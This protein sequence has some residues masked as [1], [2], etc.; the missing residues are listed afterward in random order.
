M[1]NYVSNKL[2][3]FT[4]LP[5][6]FLLACIL[7]LFFITQSYVLAGPED[8]QDG[9]AW[10][11]ITSWPMIPVS[12]A[13][14]PD[15]RIIAWASN[16][17][18]TFP[19]SVNNESTYTAVWDPQSNSFIE[20][21]HPSHDMF[22]SHHV[23]LEDGNVFVSGGRNQGNTP[24]TSIFNHQTNQWEQ[25]ANMN[26]G[27]W[28][29]TS[30]ALADGTI[31]TA[32]GSGG[33]NTAE[34]WDGTSSWNLLG[35]LNFD[36]PILNYGHGERDWWPLLH[37]A[38]DGQIFHSGPTPDMHMINTSGN[39][40]I[41]QT[42]THTDWYPKHGATVMY[43]E[44]KLLTAG[45]WVGANNVSSSNQAMV[46][47][48]NGP[49]PQITPIA[50]M[51]HARKFQNGVT[52]PNG[53]VLIVGGNTSGLK[54]DDSGTIYSVEIWNPDTQLW[55]EGASM[56]VPRNYHSVALL[57]LDGRV[58]SAGGGLCGCS[59]DHQDHQ[60][61]S[62]PYLF[63]ADGSHA[64]RPVILQVPGVVEAGQTI[65]VAATAGLAEFSLVKMSSTTHA[66]NTD[67]RYLPVTMNEVTPGNYQ[68]NLHANTNVLTPGY[69]M[70]F[71]LNAQGTPSIAK[72]IRVSTQGLQSGPPTIKQMSDLANRIQETVNLTLVTS[73]P[74]GEALT[75]TATNLPPGLTLNSLSGTIT[76]A[77]N[78]AG[79]YNTTITVADSSGGTD[80][81]SFTW[82]VLAGAG[83]QGVRYEYYQ[84]DWNTLPNFDQLQPIST[85]IIPNFSISPAAQ[86]D[87][88]GFRYS[89]QITI[90]TAGNY[91]FYTNSDDGS[92]L[93]INDQLVVD[94]NGL[95]A[96][97]ERSGSITL[98]AGNHDIRVTFFEKTGGANLV[99]SYAGPNI[100]KQTIPNSV[101]FVPTFQ[102]VQS[103]RYVRLTAL[104]EIN[105][106]PWTSAA[107]INLLDTNGQALTRSAWTVSA[108]SMELTGENGAASNAI[109]GD[110]NTIWHTEWFSQAGDDNDPAHPHHF[111]IDLGAVNDISGLTYLP[112]P[113]AGNGTIKAYE[114]YV[115]GDGINWGT[116]IHVGEFTST[117][118]NTVTFVDEPQPT[119]NA[120]TIV[121]PGT[122]NN[123][124]GD[125]IALSISAAD[126]DGDILTYSATGLPT[127]L[128]VNS[129]TG[130]I[131]GT[132]TTAQ[133]FNTTITVSDGQAS[134]NANFSWQV[135]SSN[136]APVVT[137][138]GDQNNQVDDTISLTITATDIDNDPLTYQATGLPTGLVIN[139]ST[140]V[141]SGTLT[142][143]GQYTT[144]VSV[145]DGQEAT[146]IQFTWSVLVNNLPPT[147]DPI[148]N[149]NN[150]VGDSISL[151]LS[152]T[153]P[154]ND[155]IAYS[156]TGL[157]DGL[158]LNT[159]TG[160]I[161][162]QT[163]L[164]NV[165][166]VSVSVSDGELAS[167][168]SFTWTV[169]AAPEPIVINPLSSAP[170]ETGVTQNYVG[171]AQGDG[172]LE[173]SWLFGDGS[174]ATSFSTD[175][176]ASHVFNAPGRYLVTLTVRNQTSQA[177]TTFTQA[178]HLPLA[179]GT[180]SGDATIVY[181]DT[182]GVARVWAVNPDNDTVTVI[183]V[184]TQTKITEIATGT[185]PVSLVLD[186]ANNE[187]LV[188]NKKSASITRISLA[189]LAL[190]DEISL[191]R[192]S[193]PHGIAINAG[194]GYIYVALE[195]LKQVIQID[196]ITNQIVNTLNLSNNIRHLT[197][198]P[199]GSVLYAPLFKTP[200]I[201]GEDTSSP[202]V[203]DGN[204]QIVG[205]IVNRILT[206]S[207]TLDSPIVLP[208]SDALVS[209]HSGPGLPNYLRNLSI[210]PDGIN[211]YVPSKQDNILA[212]TARSSTLLDHDHTVRAI[213][214]QVDLV[215]AMALLN[216]RVD[217]DNSSVASAAAYGPFGN[218]LFV[219][220]E[221]NR[222]VSI[223]DAYRG[224]ELFR[225][226]TGRAP[227]G[228]VTSPDG[229]MLFVHNFL[230]RTVS[231]HDI[232]KITLEGVNQLT[233]VAS[234][235]LVAN[236]KLSPTVLLGK[237][238]FYDALDPRLTL[239]VYMSCASC[240]NDG[241]DDG[242]IWD[243]TQFGEG[244]RST[245]SL[246]GQA[247]ALHGPVHWTGN[248]DEIQDFEGQIRSFAGGLG[249][250]DDV[251][252]NQGT[253]SQPLG[254]TK[255]G[256]SPNLDALAAY[257]ESL[258]TVEPSP[259]RESDGELTANAQAGK[260]LFADNNCADCHNGSRFSDSALDTRHDV[261][262][263]DADSGQ[264]LGGLLDGLDT[265]TLRGLWM[266][267]PYLHDGS[268]DTLEGAI[269]SHTT[270]NIST[271]DA[272]LIAEYLLQLDEEEI[273]PT[274]QETLLQSI[275]IPA[276]GT[277][278]VP[279]T[280]TGSYTDMVVV[281]SIV[282]TNN[283]V[284]QITRVR[285]TANNQFE[286]RLQSPSN[287]ILLNERVDCV[288][289]EQGN[290]LLP[291]GDQFEARLY[292]SS[293][294]DRKGSWIGEQQ[295]YL[296]S[297]INPVV[298]GQ[299]MS[300]NDSNWSTFW[301]QG[302]A[303]RNIPSNTVIKTGKMVGED[304]NTTRSTE[305]IGYMVFERNSGTING[306]EFETAVG[307]DSI[308]GWN[309]SA[310][311]N[312]YS[313]L[314]SYA[315]TSIS[316]AS[317]TAMDG[318][319]GGWSTIRG[320]VF[321]NQLTISIDEDQVL[322]TERNHTTEQVSY[323]IMS[324]SGVVPLT[325]VE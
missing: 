92:Q 247:G 60:I 319:N 295:N 144:Q 189:T 145:S 134:A 300:Y 279:V 1:G 241:D 155:P 217:I 135:L 3:S 48:L 223:V 76:G 53:E 174:P 66:I 102:G 123:S 188:V 314:N 187:L 122:Q 181:E 78:Q 139:A 149:Q 297:Y 218:Y 257:L 233:N 85:G 281:C 315:T 273:A 266:S 278:W 33:G 69:W 34:L 272:A 86:A 296:N 206:D 129:A 244:L 103:T 4:K 226:V 95:H 47:D 116:P 100:A 28:Y 219:A 77:P 17:R 94:N 81:T 254:D 180:A 275:S 55:R 11:P 119:N 307:T 110:V 243:F 197:L 235:P 313:L 9:G 212:G 158:N 220:L 56:D 186:A 262:T 213:V 294:T 133:T 5:T 248:F 72:A 306:I 240:H 249:L 192:G 182:T 59:A 126:S 234:I 65:S 73:D 299:V 107:E 88:F 264:R 106:K 256:V 239:E 115:S 154:N 61:Y 260:Q 156:A 169:T 237:Q 43:D 284:P 153:D 173:Y 147:L 37:L 285:V 301:N 269:L 258:S 14:L 170:V 120:P 36:V 99:V 298:I 320:P 29:P 161:S 250:M 97:Q 51:H 236:E 42:N 194:T 282:Q 141:I 108:S 109:D 204:N 224:E 41:T 318:N 317:I 270:L 166:N 176:S 10:G 24:F 131:S 12:A 179:N 35:G 117:G 178:V 142:E 18:T 26:R 210:S 291:N 8:P 52:L 283:F 208:H 305:T 309:N 310:S 114:I 325:K 191:P 263:L 195:A 68:L 293:I 229:T 288:V 151:Q 171:S 242:R 96:P 104:S 6:N 185:K 125:T 111:I 211:A 286:V 130:L 321:G 312:T 205:G 290:W 193:Q 198:S 214:S 58:Y 292:Q 221:G 136:S 91:T 31:M 62:P 124:S 128:S 143:V 271:S 39:G 146:V 232:S 98:A 215:N 267:A 22:C 252:F 138:P 251:D 25:L 289:A 20:I 238:H 121:N 308:R 230:D 13:N 16:E 274:T 30:V 160:L 137:S 67:L 157:P 118:L 253:R 163:S 90:T 172:V 64:S 228:L 277:D 207:F 164:A 190:V 168:R 324:E 200:K 112:R 175:S 196:S 79:T 209:E 21:P 113:G 32:I 89:S 150:V 140:G 159:Q 316:I 259:Y 202:S 162:G 19:S 38:P 15:G 165:F 80:A 101:L 27:R 50:S 287:N 45:G 177:S 199:D 23:M 225:F 71:A 132:V 246:I 2:Y 203:L 268:Q 93:F 231:I 74:D 303:R 70:L 105:A 63:N 40:S 75:F 280:V 84:G 82:N 167:N 245:I 265:P 148:A 152:A 57:M 261:G 54:F 216:N 184:A 323:L 255:A 302:S 49:S 311:G 7:F 127:G 46:I 83:Q 201:P 87:Y 44:G 276:V 304:P 322:D 183:N 222:M 227:Q